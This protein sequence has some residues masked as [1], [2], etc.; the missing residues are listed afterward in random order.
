MLKDSFHC[1][2]F[3]LNSSRTKLFQRFQKLSDFLD[4]SLAF[5]HLRRKKKKTREKKTKWCI[6]TLVVVHVMQ[7]VDRRLDAMLNRR[8]GKLK[9]LLCQEPSRPSIVGTKQSLPYPLLVRHTQSL[10]QQACSDKIKVIFVRLGF[11][12]GTMWAMWAS[13]GSAG[14]NDQN[15]SRFD[16]ETV[17]CNL[18]LPNVGK[19]SQ[20]TTSPL[21]TI[22]LNVTCRSGSTD[23]RILAM[24]ILMKAAPKFAIPILNTSWRQMFADQLFT[25]SQSSYFVIANECLQLGVPT[26]IWVS[27]L[28]IWEWLVRA[29]E[30]R[31]MFNAWNTKYLML[32]LFFWRLCHVLSKFFS[33]T[34]SICFESRARICQVMLKAVIWKGPNA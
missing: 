9:E 33:E 19:Q 14:F 17:F 12:D 11:G 29:W 10:V 24:G 3:L 23:V 5:P 31:R 22:S 7:E 18:Y 6:C 16:H 20:T 27:K 2:V 4:V 13:G 26:N 30:R 32:V 8:G 15:L 25:N 28:R 34:T 21:S 1:R